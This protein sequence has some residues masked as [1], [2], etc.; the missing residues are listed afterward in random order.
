MAKTVS[1]FATLTTASGSATV[2]LESPFRRTVGMKP[3]VNRVRCPFPEFVKIAAGLDTGFC[4]LSLWMDKE[5]AGQSVVT[6]EGLRVVLVQRGAKGAIRGVP[7]LNPVDY[8]LFIT[9]ARGDVVKPFGGL[10]CEGLVNPDTN[11]DGAADIDI[12]RLPPPLSMSEC[13]LLCC[14]RM[15]FTPS[16]FPLF[17]SDI[18]P[19]TNLRWFG[20]PAETELESLLEQ[21]GAVLAP[22]LDGTLGIYKAGVGEPPPFPAADVDSSCVDP[23]PDRRG[24]V[25]V[26]TSAPSA[27]I[28]TLELR[29]PA[30]DADLQFVMP[31][32][33]GVWREIDD[34]TIKLTY[35]WESPVSAIRNN[36]NGVNQFHRDNAKRYLYRCVRL[37]PEHYNPL[38]RRILRRVAA[39]S[40]PT[41]PGAQVNLSFIDLRAKR[42]VRQDGGYW[43]NWTETVRCNV[44]YLFWPNVIMSSELLGKVK[45]A[46]QVRDFE[47]N[48][49]ALQLGDLTVT[50]SIESATQVQQRWVPE[51]S[52]FAYRLRNNEVVPVDDNEAKSLAAEPPAGTVA[53]LNVPGLQRVRDAQRLGPQSDNIGALRKMAD[54]IAA[55]YFAGVT[56]R[57]T[58][59]TLRGFHAIDLG[60]RVNEVTYDQSTVTTQVVLDSLDTGNLKRAISRAARLFKHGNRGLAGLTHTDPL[61]LGTIGGGVQPAVSIGAAGPRVE[62]PI[63]PF[64]PMKI[65]VAQPMD[66]S[67]TRF[68]YSVREI[69]KSKSGQGSPNSVWEDVP[70]GRAGSAY[71]VVE[72]M[73]DKTGIM[74]NGV[75]FTGESGQQPVIKDTKLVMKPA[76][77]G[78]VV[79]CTELTVPRDESDASSA[80]KTEYW[81]QYENG[82]DGECQ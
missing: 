43:Q 31:D 81:F 21:S 69:R 80:S 32:A 74:G 52:V 64:I 48:F 79:F 38:T 15:G 24:R 16:Q 28:D 23:A 77:E 2:V 65:L 42:A 6:I 34:P 53:F 49:D 73:N 40:D 5:D 57:S 61:A 78:A 18:V 8:T 67:Q 60:G 1:V 17:G 20:A 76:P 55:Q 59:I 44:E 36:F 72:S 70:N 19:P 58:E 14:K 22:K 51:Y 35:G 62:P 41:A 56:T 30:P 25:L 54:T 71:N 33:K 10:M 12:F 75:R 66:G 13:I 63:S 7:G 3:D 29:G 68:I 9:D 47:S 27:I 4:S 26:I 37:N 50:L 11:D 82:I 39:L 45:G 46:G